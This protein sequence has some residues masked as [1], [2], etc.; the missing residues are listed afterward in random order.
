MDVRL[1]CGYSRAQRAASYAFLFHVIIWCQ[2]CPPHPLPSCRRWLQDVFDIPLVIQMTDDEKYLWKDIT[3]EESHYYAVE[4]AKDI[5]ACAHPRFTNNVVKIQKHVTFN[6]VKGIFG[7]TDS[8]SIGKISFPAIQA[9]PSFS[10]SFPQIF[11]SK[12]DV[13]CLIPCA[14]DQD[15]YFRMTRD[16]APRIGYPKPA[17]LHSTFFPALQGAQTKMSASDPNSSIFL[18]DTPKQIKDKVI[19]L[20]KD[21]PRQ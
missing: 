20:E 11:G 2:L 9:A 5:I 1:Q 19:Y 17:L 12:T 15:P 6:Q 18:T 16:V 7:F 13:P 21:S 3:L 14:I 8:D 4:N 10:N